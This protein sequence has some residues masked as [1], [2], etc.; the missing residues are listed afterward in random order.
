M[1]PF[2][3]TYFSSIR[4]HHNFSFIA[5]P[6]LWSFTLVYNIIIKKISSAYCT[7]DFDPWYYCC[8]T[9]NFSFFHS[10]V[11]TCFLMV[12]CYRL[13]QILI[14]LP[15]ASIAF[16]VVKRLI[17]LTPSTRKVYLYHLTMYRGHFLWINI[18]NPLYL[19]WSLD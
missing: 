19:Y 8:Y 5:M 1:L 14:L 18:M 13:V 15:L 4:S 12:P 16:R 6:F 11:C 3:W 2:L 9:T 7:F 17:Q 10:L